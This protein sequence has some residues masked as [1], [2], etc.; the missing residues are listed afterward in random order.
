M[1]KVLIVEDEEI[2]R[3]GLVYTIDW[4]G[5]G[6]TVVGAA[7]NGKEGLALLQQQEADIVIADILMPEMTGIEMLEAAQS[8]ALKPFKS[9]ILTSH[10]NFDYARK[11]VHLA[12]ADYLLKPVDEEELRSTINRIKKSMD[13]IK[14]YSSLAA[15]TKKQ[16]SGKLIDWDLYFNEEVSLNYYVAQA[17]YKIRDHYAEK[18]SIESIAEELGVS[19]SYLSRKFKEATAQTFLEL[20]TRYRIQ[21]AISLLKKGRYRVYEVSDM[22]GFSDYKHF[23]LVFKKYTQTSP[24]EFIKNSGGIIHK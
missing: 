19:A 5:M 13:E 3:R 1:L 23:C 10:A 21:K 15:L 4:L 14:A 12:A 7:A 20:L 9:I 18:I 22:T 2:I 24:T 11:A 16:D 8:L 17:L 6:C